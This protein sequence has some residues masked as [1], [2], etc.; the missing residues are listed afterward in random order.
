MLCLDFLPIQLPKL[1]RTIGLPLPQA[2]RRTSLLPLGLEPRLPDTKCAQICRASLCL[3]RQD[4][5]LKQLY[6]YSRLSLILK[7]S[8]ILNK[9]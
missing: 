4:S 9:R 3:S 6:R 2:S 5:P 8:W 7:I 1:N